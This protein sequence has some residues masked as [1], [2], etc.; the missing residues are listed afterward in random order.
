LIYSILIFITSPPLTNRNT[1]AA[2]SCEV[3]LLSIYFTLY[4]IFIFFWN[5]IASHRK[6]YVYKY[7]YIHIYIYIY[8][9]VYMYI[10]VYVKYVDALSTTTRACRWV[11]DFSTKKQIYIYC[12]SQKGLHVC[13]C[14]YTYIYTHRTICIC[15]YTYPYVYVYIHISP[16]K[17]YK[18]MFCGSQNHMYVCK[19]IY[20][21]IYKVRYDFCY[22]YRYLSYNPR[23]LQIYIYTYIY[24]SRFTELHKHICI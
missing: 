5:N 19:C 8:I 17:T 7:M 12:E 18:Y 22:H 13:I 4:L 21:Y 20:T 6:K 3:R 15:I 24:T 1:K 23:F 11:L 2:T 14:I 9:Y 10:Y 16:K